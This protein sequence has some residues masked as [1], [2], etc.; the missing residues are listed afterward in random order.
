MHKTYVL[1]VKVQFCN[2]KRD[3]VKVYDTLILLQDVGHNPQVP[4]RFKKKSGKESQ[5]MV[6]RPGTRFGSAKRVGPGFGA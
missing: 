1:C 4:V 2:C 3:S 6:S 5:Y